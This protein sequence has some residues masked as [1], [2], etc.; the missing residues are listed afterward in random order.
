MGSIPVLDVVREFRAI[1]ICDRVPEEKRTLLRVEQVSVLLCQYESDKAALALVQ[2][3]AK[4]CRNSTA[5]P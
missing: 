1:Q 2:E 5:R 3:Q 4:N